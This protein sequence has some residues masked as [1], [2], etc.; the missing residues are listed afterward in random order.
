MK[1]ASDL[2]KIIDMW[3]EDSVFDSEDLAAASLRCGRLHSKYLELHG[4][5]RLARSK[6]QGDLASLQAV[7]WKWYG[8][9]LTRAQID[10]LGWPYDPFDGL[11]KPPRIDV[12]KYW[13]PADKDLSKLSSRV[14]YLKVVEDTLAEILD[15]IKWRHQHIRN[16][17]EW[18]K[19]VSGA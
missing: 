11:A 12:E 9:Q 4:S 3:R 18:R 15:S 19:F 2:Q 17:V 6:A 1:A 5:A 14:S 16:A 8:G 13:I 10:E 7:K